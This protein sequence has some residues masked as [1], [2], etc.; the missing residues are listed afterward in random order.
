MIPGQAPPKYLINTLKIDFR[1]RREEEGKE[2]RG[3]KG[4]RDRR[5][6]SEKH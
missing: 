2:D 4:D 1:E 3:R 6:E 5:R